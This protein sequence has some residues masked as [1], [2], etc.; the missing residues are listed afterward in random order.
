MTSKLH[1]DYPISLLQKPAH[2]FEMACARHLKKLHEATDPGKV[3]FDR[4]LN[5]FL[6]WLLV[7]RC[8]VHGR[9]CLLL[10][11]V[12]PESSQVKS[13]KQLGTM[14]RSQPS[15]HVTTRHGT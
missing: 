8:I 11:I 3:V 10:Q 2:V 4:A 13:G 12:P 15:S 1:D 6:S 9:R 14:A 7:P 5:L